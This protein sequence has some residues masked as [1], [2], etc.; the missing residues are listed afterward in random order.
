MG[1]NIP[2]SPHANSP[3]VRPASSSRVRENI[4]LCPDGADSSGVVAS[5]PS[6]ADSASP[7]NG[8]T[9]SGASPVSV[10]ASPPS[11]PAAKTVIEGEITEETLRLRQELDAERA[12]RK[13]VETEHASV[14]DEFK[15]YKTA[16]EA[17]TPVP[18]NPGTVEKSANYR[19]LRRR[20]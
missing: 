19:F 13:Q 10:A 12:A 8:V 18:V 9:L 6:G 17:A 16:V 3:G 11:P 1:M 2:I 14:T 4:L 7:P 5:N 20:A 15:R